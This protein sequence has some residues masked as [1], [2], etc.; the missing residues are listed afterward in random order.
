MFRAYLTCLAYPG[1][2][3]MHELFHTLGGAPP[4]YYGFA[5]EYWFRALTKASHCKTGCGQ[6]KMST[7][8][9]GEVL[10]K[11]ALVPF[12]VNQGSGAPGTGV[13]DHPGAFQVAKSW[14]GGLPGGTTTGSGT[15]SSA[16]LKFPRRATT[17]LQ[18]DFPAVGG[19]PGDA[20]I[21]RWSRVGALISNPSTSFLNRC[22]GALAG[23]RRL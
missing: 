18:T 9:F 22:D 23:Q 13:R 4:I 12:Q 6:E 14:T 10:K 20:A 21:L 8:W 16:C 19:T 3:L 2:T 11:Y 5:I 17:S 15:F 7:W 1:K